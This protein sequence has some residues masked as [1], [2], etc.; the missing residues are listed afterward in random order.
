MWALYFWIHVRECVVIIRAHRKLRWSQSVIRW[1]GAQRS[2]AVTCHAS[3][4]QRVGGFCLLVQREAVVRVEII[5]RH[6]RA[7]FWI[8]CVG[9]CAHL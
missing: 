9:C 2:A 7:F 6:V 5:Y 8:R 3:L 4:I 1:K